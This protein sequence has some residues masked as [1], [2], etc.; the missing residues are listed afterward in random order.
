ML[1]KTLEWRKESKI[2]SILEESSLGKDLGTTFYTSNTDQE[3]R[4]VCYNLLGAFRNEELYQVAF[5]TEEK[6]RDFLRWRVQL[7]EKGIE[8]L[9]FGPGKP[10]SFVHVI[11]L[12]DAPGL[13]K[14]EIR[15]AMKE[16]VELLQDNYP[17][18]VAKVVSI[19]YPKNVLC[20]NLDAKK[21]VPQ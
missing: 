8:K 19:F 12:K 4:P 2:D 6:K 15:V 21:Y 16:V 14:K 1:E 18:F 13:S 5:G 20:I 3:G 10:S 7:M 17:E 9:E 11:D